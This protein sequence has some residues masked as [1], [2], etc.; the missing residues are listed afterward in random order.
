MQFFFF[1]LVGTL[2]EESDGVKSRTAASA[3]P[4]RAP[5]CQ[6]VCADPTGL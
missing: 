6:R 2:C 4:R 5:G 3:S 1:L